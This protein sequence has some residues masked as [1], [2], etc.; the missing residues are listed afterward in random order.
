MD[1]NK[2]FSKVSVILFLVIFCDKVC[3][4][5]TSRV[6]KHGDN[7]HEKFYDINSLLD[8]WQ[9]A[10]QS[11]SGGI[12]SVPDGTFQLDPIEF[13]GPCKNQVTFQL[14]GTLQA[15]TGIINGDDWIKFHNID[16]LIIQGSGTLDGQGASAWQDKCP[17]CPPLTTSLTLSSVTNAQVTGITSLNSKGYHIKVNK[18]G[19]TT[20]EHVTIT[21]PEDSPNTDGIHTSEANNINILNSDIGTGDDC[22]SI[23]EGTQNINITGINCGPGH[24]IS[25]GS[26]GKNADDGSVSGVHVMSCTMT[27][28][29]N[30]VRIKTW[31]S[32]CSATVSDVTFHD[33]TIDQASNPIIIDQQYC[34]GSHECGEDPSHVQVSD[35]KFINVHGISKSEV[36]INLQ[37]SSTM[38]CQ[39]IELDTIDLSLDGGEQT[40]ASCSNVNATYDG[41]QNPPPCSNSLY[42]RHL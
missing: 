14:D 41:S 17:S 16:G 11:E 25:I 5:D 8:S 36:A 38:P 19:G 40:T 3:S 4:Y 42:H 39:G 13:E 21:A 18:G 6:K 30:G 28:T 31:T 7:A 23:G 37:C 1:S 20:I 10:C 33:I 26:I 15:P 9:E 2:P 32:D 34:G 22:I 12:V 35:V 29:E 27:S 24:G